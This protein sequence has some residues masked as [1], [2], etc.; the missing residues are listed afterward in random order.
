MTADHTEASA[1][2]GGKP[3]PL[4][5]APIPWIGILHSTA[6]EFDLDQSFLD[7]LRLQGWEGDPTQSLGANKQV[8]IR[9]IHGGG[10]YHA[11]SFDDLKRGVNDLKDNTSANLKLIVAAGGLVGGLAAVQVTNVPV[12]VVLGRFAQSLESTR[13]G[14]FFFDYPKGA[15]KN[16]NMLNKINYLT[17]KY[18]IDPGKMCL[19]YNGNSNMAAAELGDWQSLN[20]SGKFLDASN[21]QENKKINFKT[22]FDAANTLLGTGAR[23]IVLSA[24]PFFAM[25][26]SRII[27]NAQKS[28]A[29][30]VMCYPLWEYYDDAVNDSGDSSSTMSYGPRLR[31]VYTNLG[32]LAGQIL[33][34]STTPISLTQALSSYNGLQE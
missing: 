6:L 16:Q 3:G 9:K 10:R 7:G 33:T 11:N 32:T 34:D 28:G 4:V 31:D 29:G 17:T 14:G 5:P 26:R 13:I 19:L 18:S 30:L 27:R 8:I 22:V 20:T 15:T 1:A 21:G 25:K 2:Y 24:D 12:L 23:A